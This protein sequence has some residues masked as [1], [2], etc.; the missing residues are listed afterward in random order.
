MIAM[1]NIDLHDNFCTNKKKKQTIKALFGTSFIIVAS[2]L[3]AKFD[4]G[5][6]KEFISKH[7]GTNK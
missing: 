2:N 6:H 1:F 4:N 3:K 5:L 7:L